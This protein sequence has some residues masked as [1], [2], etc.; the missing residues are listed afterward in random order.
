MEHAISASLSVFVA[1]VLFHAGMHMLFPSRWKTSVVFLFTIAFSSLAL[2]LD[3]LF[4]AKSW[5]LIAVVGAFLIISVESC[6]EGIPSQIRICAVILTPGIILCAHLS[7]LQVY[8]GVSLSGIMRFPMSVYLCY[9]LIFLF[10]GFLFLCLFVMAAQAVLR[11]EENALSSRWF[12]FFLLPVSQYL[13]IDRTIL[14]ETMEGS[15]LQPAMLAGAV[16]ISV[17]A[18]QL[19]IMAINNIVRNKEI[20][21]RYEA[22]EHQI[23]AK[24]TYYR[25]LASHYEQIQYLRHDLNNHVS[26]MKILLEKKDREELASYLETMKQTNLLEDVPPLCEHPVANLFLTEKSEEL[27]KDGIR[28]DTDLTLGTDLDSGSLLLALESLLGFAVQNLAEGPERIISLSTAQ[29]GRRTVLTVSYPEKDVANT[30]TVSLGEP[31]NMNCSIDRKAG[32]CSV[33]FALQEVPA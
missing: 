28:L 21:V 5:I 20:A 1:W 24:E 32:R 9:L 26:A 6:F 30:P 17:A 4:P 10:T 22:L 12:L 29:D 27:K 19:I 11:R 3:L 13:L 33:H 14:P 25:K 16:I 7:R 15:F 18:D 23:Q 2:L 8:P 31:R